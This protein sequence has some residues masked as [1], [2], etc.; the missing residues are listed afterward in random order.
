[1]NKGHYYIGT[2]R[3]NC[4]KD[5]RLAEDKSL[6]KDG[7][8]SV[9]HRC[10]DSARGVVVMWYDNKAV[11][12]LSSYIGVEPMDRVQRWDTCRSKKEHVQVLSSYHH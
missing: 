10:E 5:C 1:M 8:G 6:K 9:D 2:V 11:T 3:S 4:L 7:R 12:L